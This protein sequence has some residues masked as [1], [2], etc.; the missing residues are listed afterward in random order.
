MSKSG[1][2]TTVCLLVF[3]LFCVVANPML[4]KVVNEVV[5]KFA[6]R[7]TISDES[8]CPKNV[9]SVVHALVF[10]LL[11]L[12]LKKASGLSKKAAVD[13]TAFIV[14]SALFW[15]FSNPMSYKFVNH[16]F[17]KVLRLRLDISSPSGCPTQ[18]GVVV[19]G[20]VFVVVTCVL[21][22]GVGAF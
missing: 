18:G 11:L 15:L 17:N 16:L 7:N 8:G 2:N 6:P 12:V 10:T 14:T 20:V 13:T 19:H 1:K 22:K 9:G 4:F 21:L 5:N 3:V